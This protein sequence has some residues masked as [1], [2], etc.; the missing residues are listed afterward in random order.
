MQRPFEDGYDPTQSFYASW[1]VDEAAA[2]AIYGLGIYAATP[3]TT[4]DTYVWSA[5]AGL[6]WREPPGCD[7]TQTNGPTPIYDLVGLEP[8]S[9]IVD[10]DATRIT[11]R[12]TGHGL[13]GIVLSSEKLDLNGNRQAPAKT[14]LFVDESGAPIAECDALG[15]CQRD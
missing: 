14:V 2:R 7:P 10:Q 3:T 4:P 13:Q 11:V 9:A 12:P 8:I 15:V 1:K 6:S 5:I